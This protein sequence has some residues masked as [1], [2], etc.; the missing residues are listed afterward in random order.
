MEV[1]DQLIKKTIQFSNDIAFSGDHYEA[2]ELVYSAA[3]LIEE[4]DFEKSLELYSHNINIWEKLINTLVLQ[5]L[6]HEIAE[7]HLRIS[8]LYG[9]KFQNYKLEKKH[10]FK[11]INVL[12]EETKLLKEFNEYRKLSQNYQ[13]I[14]ELY[15]KLQKFK[16]AIKYY[17]KVIEIAE[18]QRYLDLLSYSY[19]RVSSCYEELDDYKSSKDIILDGITYF[20]ELFHKFEEKNDNLAVAQISQILKKLYDI[21]GDSD[22]FLKYTKK[23]AGAYINLAESIKKSK[24]NYQKISRYYRGAALCYK[25]LEDNLL[26]SA[27]CFV[28]AGNY[29]EKIERFNDAGINFIDAAYIFKQLNNME[30]TYKNFIRSGDAF[31][32]IGEMSKSTEAYLNAYDTAIEGNLEFNRFG[33]FNQLVRGLSKI[34]EEGLK[35][36]QFYTAAKLILESI[37][38]Y[39]QLDSAKDFFLREMLKNL[40]K[41]YYRAADL[42]RI[43]YGHIVQSYILAALSSILIGKLDKAQDIMDEIESE[44]LTV[45][46]YIKLINIII[47]KIKKHEKINIE[48]FPYSITRLVENSEDISYLLSLFDRKLVKSES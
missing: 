15:L 20:S 17:K 6:F 34:A 8:E 47:Q 19:Q 13:H 32:K 38:F 9:E 4:I 26:E 40:Y 46:D 30:Q 48:E 44:T 23:E 42:K 39:E 45:K 37:K 12:K 11:C 16:G 31:W 43:G 35:N 7:I 27:S 33:I 18:P 5:G 14:A 2:G 28:L 21:I 25:E 41:Y 1:L 29:S 10:I 22:Q 3:E 36:K 24:N